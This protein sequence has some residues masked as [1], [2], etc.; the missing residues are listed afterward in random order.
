MPNQDGPQITVVG[1]RGFIGSALMERSDVTAVDTTKLKGLAAQVENKALVIAAS[2]GPVTS[3]ECQAYKD[4]LKLIDVLLHTNPSRVVYLSTDTV[5]PFIQSI[6]ETTPPQP[7]SAYADMHLERERRLLSAFQ[8]R[9]VIARLSQVYGERDRHNA[10]GPMRMVRS[11][12]DKGVIHIFGQGEE[13]RDH[14][15][16]K[17]AV[18][19]I[20]QLCRTVDITGVVNIASGRSVSF[21][22]LAEIVSDLVPCRIDYVSRQQPITHRSLDI[23]RLMS[24]VQGFHPI[25][26]EVG[27][28]DMIKRIKQSV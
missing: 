2:R 23:S 13:Q 19:V 22:R 9:I 5:Y 3:L 18:Y 12:I 16:L 27:I 21:G 4:N 8:S 28:A 20:E 1:A 10:Y 15:A 26:V 14:I 6:N 7:C 17:D 25:P 24:H 11:A